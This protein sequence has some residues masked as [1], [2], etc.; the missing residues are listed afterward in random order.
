MLKLS[1]FAMIVDRLFLGIILT[2]IAIIPSIN[3]VTNL[4]DQ[5]LLEMDHNNYLA[6]SKPLVKEVNKIFL[7]VEDANDKFSENIDLNKWSKNPINIE[8]IIGY[9]IFLALIWESPMVLYHFLILSS[10]QIKQS[11][12][13]AG[14]KKITL[15]EAK[16][17]TLI[18][19]V[20]WK[21]NPH[22]KLES[23]FSISKQFDF[24]DKTD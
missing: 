8:K 1:K 12:K 2:K 9:L 5:V 19:T 13:T 11:K 10:N 4:Y 20:V 7:F 17:L 23:T 16:Y 24:M 3:F 22:K 15:H 6:I 21:Q 18:H 14:L